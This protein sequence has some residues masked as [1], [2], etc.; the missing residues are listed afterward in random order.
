VAALDKIG[1][2]ARTH[3]A[4]A[5]KS[6]AG[7]DRLRCFVGDVEQVAF[8]APLMAGVRDASVGVG[9]G[10]PRCFLSTAGA[11]HRD[12]GDTCD[13]EEAE[14]ELERVGRNEVSLRE[15]SAVGV[16]GSAPFFAQSRRPADERGFEGIADV[17]RMRSFGTAGGINA[18]NGAQD[19]HLTQ[20]GLLGGIAVSP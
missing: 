13:D 5:E 14:R 9:D 15:R 11:L 4:E 3:R 7:H 2:H 17:A 6:N 19:Y 8:R 18:T 16:A 12:N 20:L 10:A 1:R